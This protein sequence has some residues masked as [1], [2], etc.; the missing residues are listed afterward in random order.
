M[1]LIAPRSVSLVALL[2]TSACGATDK[3]ILADMPHPDNASVAGAAAAAAAAAT[4]AD[5][6]A[7]TRQPEKK[8]ET[9]KKPVKVKENVPSAVFDRLEKPAA[10]SGSAAG[11]APPTAP[12]AATTK[13]GKPA[14][15]TLKRDPS[16][17]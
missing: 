12:A 10:G 8:V 6:D 4:L 5:P 13:A 17:E 2:L 7:A 15:L 14:D 11:S 16:A 9:E 3:P 1:R